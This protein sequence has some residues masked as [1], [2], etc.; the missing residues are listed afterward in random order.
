[1]ELLNGWWICWFS[2]LSSFK[3]VFH[4]HLLAKHVEGNIWKWTQLFMFYFYETLDL[5]P[6]N[7]PD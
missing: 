2:T 7:K 5:C 4:S 3:K 6:F 1:M